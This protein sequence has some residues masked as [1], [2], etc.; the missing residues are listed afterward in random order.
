MNQDTLNAALDNDDVLTLAT[1][2][3]DPGF[4]AQVDTR[5]TNGRTALFRAVAA[6]NVDAALF[7]VD[8]GANPGIADVNDETPLMRAAFLGQS[9]LVEALASAGAD[10]NAQARTGGTALHYAYA[11]STRNQAIVDQLKALGA[12]ASKPAADGALP[13]QWVSQ[14]QAREA[15]EKL[16]AQV[17]KPRKRGTL[18]LR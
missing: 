10:I 1:L 14:A 12:D 13:E 3:K 15:G 6:G 8:N 17:E 4:L 7:L 5:D 18:S 11:G 9:T 2:A 16:R